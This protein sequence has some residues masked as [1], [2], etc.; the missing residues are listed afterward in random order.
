MKESLIRLYDGL[1]K[2]RILTFK[3]WQKRMPK[4]VNIRASSSPCVMT[5]KGAFSKKQFISIDEPCCILA[6]G[7]IRVN[8][9]VHDSARWNIE[10]TFDNGSS[11]LVAGYIEEKGNKGTWDFEGEESGYYNE[12]WVA[13]FLTPLP[14]GYYYTKNIFEAFGLPKNNANVGTYPDCRRLQSVSKQ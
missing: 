6:G 11:E 1:A 4:I 2:E 5:L 8:A 7:I 3:A 9:C 12:R 14:K 13:T 10:F